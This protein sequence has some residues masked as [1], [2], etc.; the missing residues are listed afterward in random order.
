MKD[1]C[2]LRLTITLAAAF[3]W[4]GISGL[5]RAEESATVPTD[6]GFKANT[7]QIN[8]GVDKTTPSQ[9]KESSRYSDT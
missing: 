1:R 8:P 6:P 2:Y 5:T 7:G 4:F 3:V 9:S